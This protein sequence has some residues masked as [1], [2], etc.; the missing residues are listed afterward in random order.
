[1]VLRGRGTATRYEDLSPVPCMS[2][3]SV[4]PPGVKKSYAMEPDQSLLYEEELKAWEIQ[5]SM[6][7]LNLD[8][9]P[10][11]GEGV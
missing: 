3:S 2:W 10:L 8:P 11:N 4:I 5:D 6:I 1:M 7:V 9:N